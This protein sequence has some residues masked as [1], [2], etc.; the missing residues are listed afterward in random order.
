[1]VG[2]RVAEAMAKAFK[3]QGGLQVNFARVARLDQTGAK[4]I[5]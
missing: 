1:M 3:E 5:N 4:T 2:E